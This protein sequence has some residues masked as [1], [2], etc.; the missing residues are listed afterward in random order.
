MVKEIR[1]S[2]SKYLCVG[3]RK[4]FGLGIVIDK[5]TLSIDLGIFWLALEW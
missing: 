5:F 1:I 3:T 2:D 4:G